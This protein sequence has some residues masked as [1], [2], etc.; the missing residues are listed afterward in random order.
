MCLVALESARELGAKIE[1]IH[2][3]RRSPDE[4]P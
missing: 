1:F 2:R 3:E 4:S